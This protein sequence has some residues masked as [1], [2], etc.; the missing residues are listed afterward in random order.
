MEFIEDLPKSNGSSC[1]LVVV[2]RYAKYSHFIP[3]KHPYTAAQI[4][5]IF[6][7]QVVKLHGMPYTITSDRDKIFIS[8]LWKA[9]VQTVGH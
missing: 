1:I 8:N 2:D 5:H 6:L 7:Q 9:F 4:A 3:L